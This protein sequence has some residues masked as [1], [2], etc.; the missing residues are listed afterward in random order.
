M[1]GRSRTSDT[2]GLL[3][4][5]FPLQHQSN[6]I[7]RMKPGIFCCFAATCHATSFCKIRIS[8]QMFNTSAGQSPLCLWQAVWESY[9]RGMLHEQLFLGGPVRVKLYSHVFIFLRESFRIVQNCSL[10]SLCYLLLRRSDLRTS[11]KLPPLMYSS[12]C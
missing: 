3:D 11:S 2:S 9:E 6:D 7:A 5:C 4:F 10:V 8:P 1:F 12:L